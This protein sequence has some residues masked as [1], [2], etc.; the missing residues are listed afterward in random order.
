MPETGAPPALK[1]LTVKVTVSPVFGVDGEKLKLLTLTSG[2]VTTST[3]LVRDGGGT[4]PL[5]RTGAAAKV[6]A[7]TRAT[8]LVRLQPVP[9]VGERTLN[10]ADWHSPAV[11]GRRRLALRAVPDASLG[12]CAD[13]AVQHV[14][15]L[16]GAVS[17]A[18]EFP[19]RVA[20]ELPRARG[21]AVE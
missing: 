1:R 18:Q 10:Q 16:R 21:R 15:P 13:R 8:L 7:T 20:V 3:L 9:E 2:G 19:A 6:R 14:R 17:A 11:A 4:A 12:W 5:V